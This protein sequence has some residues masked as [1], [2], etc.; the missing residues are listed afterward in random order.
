[1]ASRRGTRERGSI[2]S[3]LSGSVGRG[4]TNRPRDIAV[5]SDLLKRAGAMEPET[6]GGPEAV[7]DGL[8]RFQ[9]DTGLKPDGRLGPKTEKRLSEIFDAFLSLN[10]KGPVPLDW[11]RGFERGERSPYPAASPPDLAWQWGKSL[12]GHYRDG[13]PIGRTVKPLFAFQTEDSPEGRLVPTVTQTL[14]GKTRPVTGPAAASRANAAPRKQETQGR[15]RAQVARKPKPRE[16]NDFTLAGPGG[17][18]SPDEVTNR[19]R[20]D[21]LTKTFGERTGLALTEDGVGED[22][23]PRFAIRERNG[24]PPL[25]TVSETFAER[26]AGDPETYAERLGLL[27]DYR[28]GRLSG[29]AFQDRAASLLTRDHGPDLVLGGES[30]RLD[31]R[32]AD[33]FLAAL[34]RAEAQGHDEAA[35]AALT[36]ALMPELDDQDAIAGLILDTLPAIGNIRSGQNALESGKAAIEALEK[37]DWD[38][39]AKNGLLTLLDTAG[40]IS[41]LAFLPKIARSAITKTARTNRIA[42]HLKARQFNVQ[43]KKMRQIEAERRPT[44]RDK[45]LRDKFNAPKLDEFLGDV[46]KDLSPRQLEHLRAIY[47]NLNGTSLERYQREVF[48]AI[49]FKRDP[50]Q[51]ADTTKYPDLIRP[52]K[53]IQVS[54]NG[55]KY[56]RRYDD[57]VEGSVKDFLGFLVRRPSETGTAVE[58]KAFRGKLGGTKKS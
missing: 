47:P 4:G 54:I 35:R 19:E 6:G 51:L 50:G 40:A 11:I 36:L 44:G 45:K 27:D 1:M 14:L 29:K 46:T 55:R 31:E 42:G 22:G 16:E 52:P 25:L 38:D 43:G 49:G 15:E 41:G 21:E 28:A 2:L 8:V 18:G 10:R 37:G 39:A 53:S 48:D 5:V 3:G 26:I 58:N 7:T 17:A 12:F 23:R 20:Q 30:H 34:D 9:R 24:G 56:S 13:S 57:V 32:D 33:A